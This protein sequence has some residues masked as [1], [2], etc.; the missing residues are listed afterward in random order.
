MNVSKEFRTRSF[1]DVCHA[2][3]DRGEIALVDVREEQPHARSH[4]LFAA[5]LPLS[6]LELEAPLRLPRLGVPIVVFDAGEGLARRAASRFAELGYTNVA[7]LEGGLHGWREAGG[8][9]F[10]GVNVPSK[11]FGELVESVRH[12]PSLSAQEVQA[13]LDHEANVVVLDARR[14]DEFQAMNIPGSISVPGAE[15]VLRAR[16]LA[17]DPATRIIVNCA[18]RT[19]SIIGAQSLIN[20][21][22]PN[23]VAALRNGT[24]GWTLA[25]Q[26]LAHGSSRRGGGPLDDT[27][28]LVAAEAA[29]ALADRARVGRTSRD[30]ARRWAGEEVRTVYRFDVRSPDEY[31]AGHVPGFRSAPGGQLVQETDVFVPV[32]GARVIVA[33]NDGVR[34]NM[35]A[36]WLAQ[37]NLEVFVVDGL[38]PADFAEKGAAPPPR[39]A[40]TPPEVDEI[41]PAELAALLQAPG[42]VVLDFASSTSYLKR[43]VPGAWFV[44]RSQLDAALRT[45]PDAKRYVVTGCGAILA[46]FVAPELAAASGRPVQV[47]RGGTRAWIDAG[48]PVE[49]GGTRFASPRIDRYQRPYEGTDN[50]REAI[51]AYL[52][53]EQGLLAQL[54]RDGTHGFRVI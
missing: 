2:L 5:N 53:W 42:T 15:L 11:A 23:P 31:E 54:A 7:L 27:L 49:A 22:V 38:T 3:L 35:T 33:D 47:L 45:L 12:T 21:G 52:E 14:F 41:E 34:A 1:Q 46:R 36:S 50:A 19:R 29:R 37:M 18:G 25:G 8:E 20:A 44:I 10:S 30:E 24:M 13:L 9:L 51:S 6:R 28:R 43:H 26:P 32:R 17:P 39:Y 16:Q 48:L 40:A 4:P